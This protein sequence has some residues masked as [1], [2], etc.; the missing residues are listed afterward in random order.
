MRLAI[1]A[2][3]AFLP[4]SPDLCAQDAAPPRGPV[5][6]QLKDPRAADVALTVHVL[7]P[8]QLEPNEERLKRVKLPAG[9]RIATCAEGLNNPRIISV[10]G[11]GTVYVTRREVGD[12]V[13]LR[14]ADGDGRAEAPAVVA[15]RPQMH[16][17]ALHGDKAYLAT[18][19]EV[20]VADRK[21]DGTLGELRQI[22]S[23][24]P[25]GGQHPNRTLAVGPD[26][27]LYVSVGSTC[28]ACDETSDESATILRAGLD[29]SGRTIFA[30]GLRNTIGFGWHP[31]TRAM[32][33]MDHGI[34]WLGDNEQPEELNRIEQGKQY[35]WPYV[36]ADGRFNPQ[37]E[38]KGGVTMQQWKEKSTEPLAMY[39]A[40]S[41][42]MQMAFYTGAMFPAEYRNDAFVAMRGSWNRRPP[43]GYE[44][45]RVRFDPQGRPTKIEPFASGFLVQ[46]DGAWGHLGRLC[47]VA[48]AKDG[49]LLVGDDK[50]GIIYRISYDAAGGQ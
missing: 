12:V 13:M 3:V 23:D 40:H 47:G 41:A 17:I 11:D 35:G 20:F 8:K 2:T 18:I 37:D 30:S 31:Q 32:F 45:S 6:E 46:E 10:A 49:A 5:S 1:V 9:F 36:Y 25:D 21:P 16:G 29:G 38:P 27:M 22:I 4:F 14:D 19:K 50:N 26:G 7:E 24:L 39:T 44:V 42:P 34:D 15:R 28:N 48:V 33:G 43:S